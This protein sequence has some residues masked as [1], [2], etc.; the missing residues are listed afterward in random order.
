[1][2][3]IVKVLVLEHAWTVPSVESAFKTIGHP[4]YEFVLL[5]ATNKAEAMELIGEAN[6]AMVEVEGEG[7]AVALE[8]MRREIPLIATGFISTPGIPLETERMRFIRKPELCT[9]RVQEIALE[10]TKLP[11]PAI[12]PEPAAEQQPQ[13]HEPTEHE[14]A[15]AVA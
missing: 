13:H 11:P 8:L 7:R 3:T 4:D 10:F 14:L 12:K 6:M 2:K 5:V 15:E 1:M 9:Q